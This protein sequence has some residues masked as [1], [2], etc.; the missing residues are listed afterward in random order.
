M[1]SMKTILI[2]GATAGI[3]KACA[4][5]FAKEKFRLILTGR[6]Q[7][8]LEKLKADL[9][10]QYNIPIH[11]LPF[12]IQNK[13]ATE[14]AVASLP[15]A[16]Q[17]I[18]ILLNNAGLALGKEDIDQANMNDWE[19][20]I[21][22]NVK[23]L[24]YITRAVLPL[25]KKQKAGHIINLSSIAAKEVYPQGNVYNATKHAVDALSKAMRIDLL[26]YNI[27]VTA[28][29]PG[30]VD[31]EFSVVRYKGNQQKANDTYKGFTPLYAQ[32]V[33]EVIYF[34]ATR[35]GHVN[36]NDLLLMPTAQA[37]A[38]IVQKN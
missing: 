1:I 23:G 37:T 14:D 24:L 35:P 15:I 36:I 18:D 28:I 2:T 12:D 16:F 33:A 22:T 27:K 21:D 38:T 13:K 31:T 11:L 30:M 34:A 32:D 3:G 25:M 5:I 6:R 10:K 20:M 29:A 9:T 26:P 4:E 8:R 19:T 7:K 17:Q